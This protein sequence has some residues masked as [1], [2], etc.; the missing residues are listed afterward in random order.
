MSLPVYVLN[1]CRCVCLV[2]SYLQ[3]FLNSAEL[4]I[5]TADALT[6]SSVGEDEVRIEDVRRCGLTESVT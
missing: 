5:Q 6:L 2:L 3:A 4:N 1:K